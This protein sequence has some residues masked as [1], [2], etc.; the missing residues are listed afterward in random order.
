MNTSNRNFGVSIASW[1]AVPI[2][3][4]AFALTTRTSKF[5]I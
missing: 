5:R 3:N 4:K 1:I 2:V